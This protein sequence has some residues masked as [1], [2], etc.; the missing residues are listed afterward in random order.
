MFDPFVR[1]YDLDYGAFDDDVVFYR[2]MARLYG[3]PVLEAMCGTGRVAVPLAQAGLTVT[4]VDVSAAMIERAEAAAQA[5]GVAART[6]FVQADLRTLALEA[7]FGFAF[8]AINS[9][10]H[11]ETTADQLAA[12]R[13]LHALLRP[14]GGLALDLFNP[15][16]AAL[17]E[18]SGSWV[19]DKTFTVPTSGHLVQKFVARTVDVAQQHID[20][21]FCY[22]EIDAAGQVQ[23]LVL[24][25]GMRWIYRYELEH[26][27]AR[28]GFV[29]ESVYGSYDLDDY[30]SASERLLVVARRVSTQ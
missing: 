15:D 7:Q 5:A 18:V 20:V 2:E 12:L 26:I 24:P 19:L 6:T 3:G 30:T 13:A 25:F 8:V 16:P 14:G 4:G 9:L 1:Y 17:A 27:L 29:L 23:R 11:L 22:D 21:T 28:T 10:M